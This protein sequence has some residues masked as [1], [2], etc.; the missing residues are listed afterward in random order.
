MMQ[1]TVRIYNVG[2]KVWHAAFKSIQVEKPCIVCYGEKQVTVIL[3]NGD[4]VVTPC[5]YCGK[6]FDG[7]TG[8]MRVYE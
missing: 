8:V 7:A 5:D 3:G 2:D 4:R 1:E 6:G